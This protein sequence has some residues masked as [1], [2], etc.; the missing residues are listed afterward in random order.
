MLAPKIAPAINTI[1][2]GSIIS[3][4]VT[5]ERFVVLCGEMSTKRMRFND[6]VG[7]GDPPDT[8]KRDIRGI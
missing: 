8:Q 1:I 2:K 6:L 5:E 3:S 7:T 4:V